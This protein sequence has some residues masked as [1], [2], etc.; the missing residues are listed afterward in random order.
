MHVCTQVEELLL[1]EQEVQHE[2]LCVLTLCDHVVSIHACVYTVGG[3][4]AT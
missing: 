4:A 3:A 1:L 2:M